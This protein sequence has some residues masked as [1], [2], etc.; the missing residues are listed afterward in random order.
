MMTKK[1]I[2]EK[3]LF[4]T[5]LRTNQQAS[6]EQLL[7]MQANQTDTVYVKVSF[8]KGNKHAS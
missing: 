3:M 7:H 4:K 2:V 1:I 6:C 5:I 8:P